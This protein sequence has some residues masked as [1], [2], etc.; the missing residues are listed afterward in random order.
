MPSSIEPAAF[1]EDIREYLSH[2]AH[3]RRLSPR[4]LDI[5]TRDLSNFSGHCE[6]H[7]IPSLQTLDA[8][9]VRAWMLSLHQRRLAA[10]SI[11]RSLSSLRGFLRFLLL[12]GRIRHNPADG[13]RAPK[14]A[15]P[16]P[17]T[18]DKDTLNAAL[19]VKP[20]AR[21]TAVRDHAIAELLYSSGLRLAELAG[22]DP[23]HFNRDLDEVRVLGKG[24]KERIVPVGGKARAALRQ[25][26]VLRAEKL[27]G[28]ETALFINR[29]GARLS[30]AGIAAGLRAWAGRSGLGVH[31]HPHKLRHSFATHLLEESGDL[32][33][34]QELLGHA[35]LSTTQVYTHL[36]FA[37]LAKVYD[38]AHPRAKRRGG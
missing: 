10:S 14:S 4:T 17:K 16:L 15:R 27:R 7:Q 26:L 6:Q 29:S 11:Q 25:W 30:R 31:V 3:E 13:V 24:R 1:A 8:H 38:S 19:N 21:W 36:D 32:R 37:H 12:R 22:L 34:V 20:A 9:H 35:N 23:D 28:D 2:L 18:L 33:A 5:S